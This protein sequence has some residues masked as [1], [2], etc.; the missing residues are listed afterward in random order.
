MPGNP[1][2][3]TW[4]PKSVMRSINPR[5]G[6]APACSEGGLIR[7]IMLTRMRLFLS[8]GASIGRK[9]RS[10]FRLIES[11]GLL[12]ACR[13]YRRNRVPGGT[14]FVT[15]NLLDRRSDL[16]V[17]Q[18]DILRDAVRPALAAAGFATIY[19]IRADLSIIR[20]S[21]MPVKQC[22]DRA[23]EFRCQFPADPVL[24]LGIPL[25]DGSAK[26]HARHCYRTIIWGWRGDFGLSG[27]DS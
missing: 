9:S 27:A 25:P 1:L 5:S 11:A 17:T 14:F 3:S 22:R 6:L 23:A 18:I 26:W 13:D 10:A 12:P 8:S 19:G 16:L 21:D 20:W 15:V 24:V 7:I 4:R 2:A